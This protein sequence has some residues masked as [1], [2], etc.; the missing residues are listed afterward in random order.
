MRRRST[1]C[2]PHSRRRCRHRR[3]HL[4]VAAQ[5]ARGT[6]GGRRAARPAAPCCA[7]TTCRGNASA[8]RLGPIR[9]RPTTRGRTCAST[10]SRKAQL[11]RTRHRRPRRLQPLRPRPRPATARTPRRHRRRRPARAATDA[12]DRAQEHPRVDLGRRSDSARRSGW[13]GPPRRTTAPTLDELLARHDGA[14][15][16]RHAGRASRSPTRTR[17]ATSSRSRRRGKASATRRS[18][19]Q[20]IASRSSSAT[21]P[22]STSCARSASTGTTPTTSR[23]DDDAA[24]D[25]QLRASP[26][27]LRPARSPRSPRARYWETERVDRRSDPA[28]TR[29]SVA[30]RQHGQRVGYLLLLVAMFTFFIGLAVDFSGG[31][32]H[33]RRRVHGA[34]RGHPRPVDHPRLRRQGRRTRRAHRQDRSLK[35]RGEHTAGPPSVADVRPQ[36]G[37]STIGRSSISRMRD[38]THA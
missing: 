19:R 5:P 10:R 36:R 31:T 3:E 25:T 26:A 17:R 11:A 37:R 4:L 1:S 23:L 20:S 38:T 22:C 21:T 16:P 12:S 13:P 33:R 8:S 2:A 14:G 35:T 30:A 15:R 24:L 32:T 28:S 29:A 18:S 34:R 6:R 7:T 9:S 27:P